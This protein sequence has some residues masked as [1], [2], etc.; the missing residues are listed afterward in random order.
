[1]PT[2]IPAVESPIDPVA[3]AIET[4]LDKITAPIQSRFEPVAFSVQITLDAI[5]FAIQM[6][7]ELAFSSRSRFFCA[8]VE[9][10]V[11]TVTLGIQPLVDSV[12]SC[13]EAVIDPVAPVVQSPLDPIT[14]PVG[15]TIVGKSRYCTTQRKNAQS[16]YDCLFH[17]FESPSFVLVAS[18]IPGASAHLDAAGLP[19]FTPGANIPCTAN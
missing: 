16:D 2:P 11:E 1:M 6:V 9:T 15:K 13:I 18:N 19:R 12:S 8:G 7:G 17:F 14:A 5:A 4:P 3:A 10:I